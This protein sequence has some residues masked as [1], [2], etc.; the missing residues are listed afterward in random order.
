MTTGTGG[1]IVIE[2][3]VG[4]VG[5]VLLSADEINTVVDIGL[6]RGTKSQRKRYL[7]QDKLKIKSLMNEMNYLVYKIKIYENATL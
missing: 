2:A 7:C 5:G 1:C 3:G 6:E 4:M